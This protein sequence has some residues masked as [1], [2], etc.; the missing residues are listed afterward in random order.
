MCG[1][2]VLRRVVQRVWCHREKWN[3][4][5][6]VSY[7]YRTTV[8]RFGKA[9]WEVNPQFGHFSGVVIRAE[10]REYT[11]RLIDKKYNARGVILYL[12]SSSTTLKSNRGLCD[13]LVF[14]FK[15]PNLYI[16]FLRIFWIFRRVCW[17]H[18]DTTTDIFIHP[19]NPIRGQ[20]S[21]ISL[22][23]VL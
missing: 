14:S 17:T 8:R 3:Y 5:G 1:N 19:G 15:A 18:T 13:F 4:F 22:L 2:R 6:V 23:I 9:R 12:L 10:K 21:F 20:L 11:L 16:F 7:S